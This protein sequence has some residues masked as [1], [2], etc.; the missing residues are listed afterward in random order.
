M[1]R[2]AQCM[3]KAP[4]HNHCLRFKF[5][6]CSLSGCIRDKAI[7]STSKLSRLFKHYDDMNPKV[8]KHL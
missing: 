3:T 5:Q 6:Q 8:G 4:F 1:A 7:N 2:S